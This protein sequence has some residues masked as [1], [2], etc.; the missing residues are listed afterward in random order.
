MQSQDNGFGN[1]FDNGFDNSAPI[2]PDTGLPMILVTDPAT[3]Q[4][5][6]VPSAPAT[7]NQQVYVQPQQGQFAPP[8]DMGQQQ[9]VYQQQNSQRTLMDLIF[10]N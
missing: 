3:G 7:Q 6:W 10:G 1:G 5:V 9:P 2:D 4:Q 8:A